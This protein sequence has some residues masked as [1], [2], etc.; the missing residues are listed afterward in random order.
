M[1]FFDSD[2]SLQIVIRAKDEASKVF[3]DLEK[4]VKKTGEGLKSAG[5]SLTAGLTAPL[6]ALGTASV[7]AAGNFEKS[8][9]DLSTLVG[10]GT[11]AMATFDK[12]IKEVLKTS[13][14]SAD[15]L[16]ASAYSIVSAGISDAEQALKVLQSSSDLA[17][18]GL[19][20]T[21]QATDLLTTALNAFGKD[22]SEA[23]EVANILFKT[24]KAGKT[25][26][27]DMTQAFGKMAGNASAAGI[28]LE[29]VQAATAA[30][31][32]VTGKTSESQNALAQVFLELTVAGGKLD[33]GLQEA[34]GSLE[35]LNAAISEQGLVDGMEDMRDQL[36]LTDT[37]FKNLFSSAEGGTAVFQL[38]TSANK[39]AK[40][41]YTDLA[42]G[43]E[44]M[45]DAVKAQNKQFQ[46]QWQLMKNKL[47]VAMI[48]LG[49]A[50]MPT[51]KDL[52]EKVADAAARMAEWFGNLSPQ[53]QKA[54]LIGGAIVAALGPLLFILGQIVMIA[55]AVGAAFTIM[56]GPVGVVIAIIAAL[57]AI[58]VML[59]KNWDTIKWA[60]GVAWDWIK[61][62][63]MVVVDAIKAAFN[64]YIN[65]W[66]G[67][68]D[69]VSNILKTALALIVGLVATFLDWLFP[70]WQEN[71]TA[72]IEAWQAGWEAFSNKASEIMDAISEIVGAAFEWLGGHI[73]TFLSKAKEQWLIV[74]SAMADFFVGLWEPVKEAFGAVINWIIEKIQQAIDMYEKMKSLIS[75]PIKGATSAVGNFFSSA[76]D[77]GRSILGFEHGGTVPGPIGQAVPILAHGQ[78]TILPA[79]QSATGGPTY[80]LNF[81][82]T[83]FTNE[84][85]ERR[86]R[87]MLDEYFRPLMVN[88][89][90]SA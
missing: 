19:A 10:E 31:T 12:G 47:N 81:Y 28:S 21:E 55:P 60:A 87:R 69:T 59:V 62:K 66:K 14:K 51:L 40:D 48:E 29:D 43:T 54:V 1:A 79:G 53:M 4:K 78:E 36:G 85:D 49:T 42:S 3:N 16:G 71:I 32:T 35:Q 30:L 27:A 63:I 9:G 45:T 23:D 72:M 56:T 82:D 22:A 70:N 77:K 57:I 24:V 15:E 33:K 7:I 8:M 65:F 6:A 89:K 90:I 38:L 50:I 13:P 75:K 25:T 61:D 76:I 74:W 41:T 18:A 80:N 11:E 46:Q 20:T 67:A 58:G 39:A 37:E 73:S 68:W 26:V 83:K 64:A 84:D 52:M 2:Q 5:K 34:G 86:L 17:V 88:H 44:A